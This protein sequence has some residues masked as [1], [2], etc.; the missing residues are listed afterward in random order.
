MYI[1]G[2]GKLLT[3]LCDYRSNDKIL[4]FLQDVSDRVDKETYDSAILAAIERNKQDI[5][6]NNWYD[7]LDPLVSIAIVI[8][9]L[10]QS[11]CSLNIGHLFYKQVAED[12]RKHR[13]YNG[14]SVRDLLR[15]LRN[16]RHH[17]HDVPIAVKFLYGDLPD[18]VTRISNIQSI[19]LN[20]NNER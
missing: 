9:M 17:Y 2:K 19:L 18:R 4:N 16:K 7:L 11:F 3:Q 10:S 14:K 13:S 5:V 1:F 15:A 12:L 20:P 6:R 8:C